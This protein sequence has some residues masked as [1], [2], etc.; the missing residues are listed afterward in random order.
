MGGGKVGPFTG[1]EIED[2]LNSGKATVGT[3]AVAEHRL[4]DAKWKPL[5]ELDWHPGNEPV[6]TESA[7]SVLKIECRDC[8]Q[9]IE[10]PLS[11]L[12]E[13]IACPACHLAQRVEP[14][15]LV[16]A[17]FTRGF[18]NNHTGH[19]QVTADF[20]GVRIRMVEG[21]R[22]LCI[23]RE[24]ISGAITLSEGLKKMRLLIKTPTETLELWVP[25]S[26]SKA[27]KKELSGSRFVGNPLREWYHRK[28]AMDLEALL[29]PET[30][31]SFVGALATPAGCAAFIISV[32]L[33]IGLSALILTTY[34]E[35]WSP[36]TKRWLPYGVCFIVW[37]V[38]RLL[39]ARFSSK[40]GPRQAVASQVTQ[41]LSPAGDDRN[42]SN[43]PSLTSTNSSGDSSKN[44]PGVETLAHTCPRCHAEFAVRNARPGE[45]LICPVCGS[46]VIARQDTSAEPSAHRKAANRKRILA[47]ASICLLI[48]AASAWFLIQYSKSASTDS[49]EATQALAPGADHVG[50]RSDSASGSTAPG[51][52]V[53]RPTISAST[54]TYRDSQQGLFSCAYPAKW[55]VREM[56]DSQNRRV[57]FLTSDAEIRVRI[58]RG[59]G[60]AESLA[61]DDFLRD[62]GSQLFPSSKGHLIKQEKCTVATQ[63]A[64]AMEYIQNT[65]NAHCRAVFV[66]A[67]RRLH[68]L[69]FACIN[70][71]AYSDRSR[72]FDDFLARYEPLPGQTSLSKDYRDAGKTGPVWPFTLQVGQP[73]P[74][75]YIMVKGA[76]MTVSNTTTAFVRGLHLPV[77]GIEYGLAGADGRPLTLGFDQSNPRQPKF[78]WRDQPFEVWVDRKQIGSFQNTAAYYRK[79]IGPQNGNTPQR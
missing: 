54:K 57:M 41:E 64:Y 35:H 34:G 23:S 70:E 61:V 62:Q 40:T 58:P 14:R 30:D 75:P 55:A 24:E 11:L 32:P 48:L 15:P 38:I 45:G 60:K 51:A 21:L 37:N 71:N 78:I 25:N 47:S 10:V 2:L 69:A 52:A 13:Q 77:G 59:Q 50:A 29:N 73:I 56:D 28:K 67:H 7:A 8:G 22:Q 46:T 39:P 3:L 1:A 44:F 12:G 26:E 65:P 76:T 9:H 18:F 74:M 42:A 33:G 20:E 43:A 68:V 19:Y 16:F 79:G 4:D 72:Q 17:A 49:T 66:Y 6:V 31:G 27:L 5:D 36:E 53:S 63:P